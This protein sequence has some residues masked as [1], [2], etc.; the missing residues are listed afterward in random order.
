MGLPR[1]ARQP[2]RHGTEVGQEETAHCDLRS[3]S[4]PEPLDKNLSTCVVRAQN[5]AASDTILMP[6]F[7]ARFC[8]ESDIYLSAPKDEPSKKGSGMVGGG[9]SPKH[10][11]QGGTPMRT[12][13]VIEALNMAVI[14]RGGDVVGTI[15][16]SDRASQYTAEIMKQAPAIRAAPFHGRYRNML[17]Q[18][19]CRK[20]VVNVQARVLLS[21]HFRPCIG[22]SCCS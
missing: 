3:V 18:R 11:V 4:F 15:M 7:R 17:E 14:A 8:N 13:L 12:E 10:C 1:I 9:S 20:S 6:E 16:H 2:L 21:T 5:V 19:R 22:I